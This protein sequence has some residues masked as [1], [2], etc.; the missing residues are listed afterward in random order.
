M[1]TIVAAREWGVVGMLAVQVRPW[2]QQHAFQCDWSC[3]HNVLSNYFNDLACWF[4]YYAL[5]PAVY[6]RAAPVLDIKISIL[7]NSY[8]YYIDNHLFHY[9]SYISNLLHYFNFI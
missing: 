3:S 1:N 7:I 2:P 6:K 8:L 4:A 9:A 5:Q